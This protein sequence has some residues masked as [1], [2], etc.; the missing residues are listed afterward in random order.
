MIKRETFLW[1]GRSLT[2]TY[3]DS[4]YM[5]RQVETGDLYEEA[6][7]PTECNRE[8]VE[9]D[10]LCETKQISVEDSI[11]SLSE[12]VE[13][14]TSDQPMRITREDYDVMHVH[15]AALYYVEENDGTISTIK[16]DE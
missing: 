5:I 7:D 11:E 6:T 9:T 12:K 16:G 13:S 2:R 10:I 3:S 8:Y 15:D 4:G 14:L 1:D